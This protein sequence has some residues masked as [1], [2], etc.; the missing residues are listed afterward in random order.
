MR[1]IAFRREPCAWLR[2]LC[3]LSVAVALSLVGPGCSNAN[4]ERSGI[5]LSSALEPATPL[6]GTPVRVRFLLS[7]AAGTP[8]RE[9]ALRL[10]AHMAHPGMQPVVAPVIEVRDGAYEARLSFTM[11]G[12]W[13][14]VLDGTLADGRRYTRHI[15]VPDVR[16][17][18]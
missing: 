11:A 3:L 6:T 4:D 7:D 14:L 9:A 17:G 5:R 16:A 8:V 18:G 10:E 12:D 2:A 1:P 13:I 15:D